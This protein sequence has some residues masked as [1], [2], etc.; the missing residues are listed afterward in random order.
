MRVLGMWVLV[1]SACAP[2]G[3]VSARGD[4]TVEAVDEEEL[5]SSDLGR[6]DC[7]RFPAGP[8]TF[9]PIQLGVQERGEAELVVD[10]LCDVPIQELAFAGSEAGA[11]R[12]VVEASEAPRG[13]APLQRTSVSVGFV[14]TVDEP[15]VVEGE[16][17]V[18][19]LGQD[20]ATVALVG[21]IERPFLRLSPRDSEL[22]SEP[23]CR[24]STSIAVVNEGRVELRVR[25]VEFLSEDPSLI[26]DAAGTPSLPWSIDVGEERSLN[27]VFEPAGEVVVD[28]EFQLQAEHDGT[29]AYATARVRARTQEDACR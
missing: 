2:D 25:A 5:E 17:S 26:W 11:G 1:A 3:Q 9:L 24:R 21:R 23:G 13:I 20:A 29:E 10:N 8:I 7:L 12:F 28:G 27:V 19:A 4:D 15:A 6:R 16:L 22:V 18:T 14:P